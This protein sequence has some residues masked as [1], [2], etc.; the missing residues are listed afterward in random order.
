MKIDI[1]DLAHK[2]PDQPYLDLLMLSAYPRPQEEQIRIAR[3]FRDSP[4]F[5]FWVAHVDGD[6]VGGCA[7]IEPLDGPTVIRY[8]GVTA[9]HRRQGIGRLLVETAIRRTARDRIEAE[10]D[11]NAK[12]FYAKCGFTVDCIGEKYSGVIRYLCAY[13]KVAPSPCAELGST[14]ADERA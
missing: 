8:L 10:T 2:L 12:D 9:P 13:R 7:V 5:V 3:A 14:R 1:A 4:N 11:D 6:P